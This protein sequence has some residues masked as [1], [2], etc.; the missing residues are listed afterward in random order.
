MQRNDVDFRFELYCAILTKSSYH[1]GWRSVK[2]LYFA[3]CKSKS[4]KKKT[5]LPYRSSRFFRTSSKKSTQI[6]DIFS[7]HTFFGLF[8]CHC[9]QVKKSHNFWLHRGCTDVA[10]CR[11][12]FQMFSRG[13]SKM[14]YLDVHISFYY[15]S[16]NHISLL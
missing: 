10:S 2:C 3:Q 14:A 16:T 1:N 4:A 12:V 6:P 11:E 13:F 7:L 5:I 15:F 9:V 8:Y